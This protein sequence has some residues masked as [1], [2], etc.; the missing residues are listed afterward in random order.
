MVIVV[1]FFYHPYCDEFYVTFFSTEM[2]LLFS[3]LH[4]NIL[5]GAA[6][7]VKIKEVECF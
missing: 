3:K 7:L 1:R 2:V 6:F 5:I 4:K